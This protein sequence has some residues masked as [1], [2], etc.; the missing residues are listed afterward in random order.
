MKRKLTLMLAFMA[1]ICYGNAQGENNDVSTANS[2]RYYLVTSKDDLHNGDK[3]I[4]V[5]EASNDSYPIMA[6]ST[7][8]SY[9]S[10]FAYKNEDDSFSPVTNMTT[11]NYIRRNSTS[12]N[13]AFRNEERKYLSGYYKKFSNDNNNIVLNNTFNNDCT[14]NISFSSIDYSATVSFNNTSDR[15]IGYKSMHFNNYLKGNTPGK[16][17]LYRKVSTPT[18]TETDD[19]INNV[20]SEYIGTS[21][22]TLNRTFYNDSW[23]TWCM[24]F[25][26][27]QDKIH[28]V[29]GNATKVYAY[30]KIENGAMTFTPLVGYLEAGVPY[31]VWPE[32]ETTNPTFCLVDFRSDAKEQTITKDGL[33]FC[34]T[35]A[36]CHLKEDGT[37]MFI[38]AQ[39]KLTTPTESSKKMYGLRAFIRIKNGTSNAKIS[40]SDTTDGL[41]STE[42]DNMHSG[43]IYEMTGKFAGTEYDKLNKGIY[44]INGI[45]T[46]KE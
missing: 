21:N 7:G 6:E 24:P 19:N 26:I 41:S 38:N 16:I 9:K 40:F 4:I 39:N 36:P 18:L 34:G 29:F 11:L 37:E 23:N 28:E 2:D 14:L 30:T 46:I 10:V 13:Y 32:N 25:D 3:V 22:V 15:K 33:S 8:S 45:K 31:L 44:I 43:K 12:K 5:G 17:W 27:T 1:S 42:K 35:Y 20:I